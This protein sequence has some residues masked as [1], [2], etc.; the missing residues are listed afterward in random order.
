MLQGF[1]QFWCK[2]FTSSIAVTVIYNYKHPIPLLVCQEVRVHPF[3][4]LTPQSL[5]VFWEWSLISPVQLLSTSVLALWL[6]GWLI[7]W[8]IDNELNCQEKKYINSSQNEGLSS[9][10]IALSFDGFGSI[11]R[12]SVWVSSDGSFSFHIFFPGFPTLSTWV[13]RKRLE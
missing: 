9:S 3:I 10:A 6:I 5:T 1:L 13:S 12:H 7:D 4:S 2:Y 11:S 8:L